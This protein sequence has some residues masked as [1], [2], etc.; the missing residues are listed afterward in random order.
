MG[1]INPPSVAT[2]TATSTS[3]SVT[4]TPRAS[5]H[6]AFTLGDARRALAAAYKTQS[7]TDARRSRALSAA[8]SPATDANET[9]AV[10]N[11]CGVRVLDS[12]SLDAMTLRIEVTGVSSQFSES[13]SSV[14]VVGGGGGL[15]V[16][17]GFSVAAA[18]ADGEGAG[19]A[20]SPIAARTSPLTSIPRGPD[21]VIVLGSMPDS[22][23]SLRT[24]GHIRPPVST[25][26]DDDGDDEDD[27][28]PGAGAAVEP[29]AAAAGGG[30]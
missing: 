4:A 15:V 9:S 7:F 8:R 5:S 12:S 1:V 14:D 30:T 11:S 10:T 21:G 13:S 18:A 29:A 16:V 20:H 27:A 25:A 24:D 28:F 22:A 3:G 19:A 6:L 26:A 23:R 17:E 2:A